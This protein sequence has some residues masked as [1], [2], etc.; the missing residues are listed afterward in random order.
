M[1]DEATMA[2]TCSSSNPGGLRP[3]TRR[4]S[5][6]YRPVVIAGRPFFR[7]I[8]AWLITGYKPRTAL[9]NNGLPPDIHNMVTG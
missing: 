7:N 9:E 1:W 8:N 3:R 4:I 6:I 5:L 2:G